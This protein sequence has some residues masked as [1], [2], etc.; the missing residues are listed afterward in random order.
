M[1]PG[2][3][4]TRLSFESLPQEGGFF[5]PKNGYVKLAV[6]RAAPCDR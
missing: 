6:A 3:I 1:P 2:Q 4:L 5:V